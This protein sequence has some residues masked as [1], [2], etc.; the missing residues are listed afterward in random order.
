M[1]YLELGCLTLVSKAKQ[2]FGQIFLLCFLFAFRAGSSRMI[3]LFYI[4]NAT[5]GWGKE[6]PQVA[7][8]TALSQ[9]QRSI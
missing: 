9:K 2:I 4:F 6:E 8:Q 1:I 3:L 7:W 5:G